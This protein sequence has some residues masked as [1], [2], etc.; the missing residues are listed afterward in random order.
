VQAEALRIDPYTMT[1]LD[2]ELTSA[3]GEV[4]ISRLDFGL[5]GGKAHHTMTLDLSGHEPAV[6]TTIAWQGLGADPNLRPFLDKVFPNVFVTGTMDFSARY[7][8]SGADAAQVTETVEGNSTMVVHEGYLVSD[9]TPQETRKVFPTLTLSH[10]SFERAHIETRT[11]A[12][13]SHNVMRFEAPTVN[14][15]LRGWTDNRT[16]EIDYVMVVDLVENLGLGRLRD[17]IPDALESASQLEIA[18]IKGTI[19]DQEVEYL[20]PQANK[21]KETLKS[22]LGLKT[23]QRFLVEMSPEEKGAYLK[24]TVGG[25]LGAATKPFRYLTRALNR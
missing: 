12:G 18:H 5:N 24:G 14:I 25:V 17:Q 1:D 4:Q 13:R 7:V 9:P 23:L 20:K 8:G 3:R 22:L 6:T 10:Y 21:I 19:D 2:M 11:V 15:R 16:G